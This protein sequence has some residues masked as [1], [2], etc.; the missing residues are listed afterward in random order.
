MTGPRHLH[1]PPIASLF[2][3]NQQVLLYIERDLGNPDLTSNLRL[4]HFFLLPAGELLQDKAVRPS[5]AQFP[6]VSADKYAVG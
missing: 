5:D 2:Q 1:N 4:F 6:F 3:Q